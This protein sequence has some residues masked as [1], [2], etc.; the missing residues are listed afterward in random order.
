MRTVILCGLIFIGNHINPQYVL[1]DPSK[2]FYAIILL[3]AMGMDITDFI[4]SL[5][6]KR[7]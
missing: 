2:T 5:I 1:L 7:H 6:G 4:N 3:I